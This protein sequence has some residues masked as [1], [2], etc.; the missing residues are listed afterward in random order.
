VQHNQTEIIVK[1]VKFSEIQ[2]G[3]WFYDYA[4]SGDWMCKLDAESARFSDG[5]VGIVNPACFV[6]TA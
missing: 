6:K 3:A 5:L 1:T 4:Y 2:I